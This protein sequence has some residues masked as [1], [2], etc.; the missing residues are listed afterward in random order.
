MGRSAG[1]LLCVL[2]LIVAAS[3]PG[4]A[5]QQPSQGQPAE[6]QR[7]MGE[8]EKLGWQ[9]GPSSG[10]IASHASIAIPNDYGFLAAGDTARFLTL[11]KN[12][13]GRDSYTIAP[14]T[15]N[16]FAIFSFDDIGYVK[17]DEKIDADEVLGTLKENNARGNEERR[18]RGFPV[19]FLEGWFIPPH[20][21]PQTKRLEWATRLRAETGGTN[22][23]YTIRL[24]GR[25]G[26][27]TAIL[28][29][30]PPS[31]DSDVRAFKEVLTGFAFD[32]G[33]RYAEFRT[34]DKIA[35][36][37]LTGLIVGGAAAAAAKTG[38]FKVIGKFA[39]FIFGALA[40]AVGGVFKWLT[41]RGRAA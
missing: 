2:G 11:L 9:F 41:G 13:P 32:A 36:Y 17:D 33:E 24:L 27:M 34:G 37:G 3:M 10:K 28:A 40:V 14:K 18:R 22:V 39:V 12:L 8:I 7:L 35:E 20:Y 16:W 38:L 26:V 25:T 4:L 29:T 30:D 31:L 19:I 23:N 5:Q 6:E 1:T 15:L 21:D